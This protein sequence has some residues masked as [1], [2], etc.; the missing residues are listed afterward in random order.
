MSTSLRSILLKTGSPAVLTLV[1]AFMI[2]G[3][4][5]APE[6]FRKSF[7]AGAPADTVI[8]MG[9]VRYKYE[10]IGKEDGGVK[11]RSQFLSNPNPRFEDKTMTCIVDNKQPFEQ[12]IKDL[13]NCTGELKELLSAQ[14]DRMSGQTKQTQPSA[15]A[16][17]RAWDD[18]THFLY[19][20]RIYDQLQDGD[21]IWMAT[22]GGLLRY[23]RSD[24]SF[25]AYTKANAPLPGNS[26]H[27]LAQ[28]ADGSLWLG[29]AARS[30]SGA[31]D[32]YAYGLV[33][34]Y[35]GE[36][37]KC[38]RFR[39]ENSPL[40]ANVITA[41]A[42]D[43]NDALWVATEDGGLL[44]RN[45]DG[46]WNVL[47]EDNLYL[48]ESNINAMAF[49]A[50]GV[51]WFGTQHRG[52]V[53]YDPNRK[54]A[55]ERW[56]IFN[57]KEHGLQSDAIR[58]IAIDKAG[59]IWVVLN[60]GQGVNLLRPSGSVTVPGVL[61]HRPETL[62]ALGKGPDGFIW[63]SAEEGLWKIAGPG[64]LRF[65]PFKPKM[66]V[67]RDI[68]TTYSVSVDERSVWLGRYRGL[69][70]VS[71]NGTI[72]SFHDHVAL[73]FPSYEISAMATSKEGDH[74][75]GIGMSTIGRYDADGQWTFWRGDEGGA[76]VQAD[77]DRLR[78]RFI[79]PRDDG[80]LLLGAYGGLYAFSP[81]GPSSSKL[82]LKGLTEAATSELQRTTFRDAAS[83]QN[84]GVWLAANHGLLYMQSDGSFK[85]YTP[86][87]SGLPAAKI[88][89]LEYDGEGR[90]WIGTE[91]GL[92]QMSPQSE[93]FNVWHGEINE[94]IEIEEVTSLA[95]D[96]SNRVYFPITHSSDGGVNRF[97]PDTKQW[98][99]F[100]VRAEGNRIN[101]RQHWFMDVT[102]NLA[103]D[104]QGRIW[105]GV[106]KKE[107]YKVSG[108]AVF[109]DGQWK[110]YRG[111]NSGLPREG[112]IKRLWIDDADR[113][114]IN[115]V[116]FSSGGSH[117]NGLLQFRPPD[118]SQ[119]LLEHIYS[120]P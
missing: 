58:D 4:S 114:W 61:R 13:S 22:S 49:A 90:L 119:H 113:I 36:P 7:R 51:V 93:T 68:K 92:V 3:C 78:I 11:I 101:A 108:L 30:N 21:A 6:S 20:S 117:G 39:A 79:L 84:G 53:R 29:S 42:T 99:E 100:P 64:N 67:H 104:A 10:I 94:D 44:R 105:M 46:Q 14:T 16:P 52:V 33:H 89:D 103:M 57:E 19:R 34:F 107:E 60:Y 80:S 50:N 15:N 18:W 27:V 5:H 110:M 17:C 118:A 9:S 54:Q 97:N 91:K 75:F 37:Q 2:S 106:K 41:L 35:P 40:P 85:Q 45:S 66:P 25:S 116:S 32:G 62:D 63:L 109:F 115:L 83:D 74:W 28:S 23:N 56:T 26:V 1:I 55:K 77:G 47:S 72:Q 8:E 65:I 95:T 87:N 73:G 102:S 96:Q 111:Q 69:A 31:L 59:N 112:K 71:R 24:D 88:Y 86:D 12:A 38:K 48:P 76:P 81:A 120:T 82:P 43:A 98:R 70:Q